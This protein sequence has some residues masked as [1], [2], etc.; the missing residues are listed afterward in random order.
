MM[1]KFLPG[2]SK[3]DPGATPQKPARGRPPKP[4]TPEPCAFPERRERKSNK[5]EI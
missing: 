1:W 2:V 5:D 3:P 4:K